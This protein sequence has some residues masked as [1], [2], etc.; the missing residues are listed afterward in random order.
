MSYQKISCDY[1]GCHVQNL[2]GWS[3]T[4]GRADVTVQSD[5]PSAG[6][7][8]SCPGEVILCSNKVLNR[9]MRLTYVTEGNLLYS[10]SANINVNLPKNTH[11]E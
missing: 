10:P 1:E 5:G 9:G 6:K 7:F 2:S 3:E 4:Q 8:P 11:T